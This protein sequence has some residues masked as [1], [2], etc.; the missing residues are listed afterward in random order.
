LGVVFHILPKMPKFLEVPFLLSLGVFLSKRSI[1]PLS[2]DSGDFIV[3]LDLLGQPKEFLDFRIQFF[4]QGI[5]EKMAAQGHKANAFEGGT[6]FLD[7]FFLS[8]WVPGDK[9]PQIYAWNR[10]HRPRI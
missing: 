1:A 8:G 6:D 10:T 7:K 3:I 5:G 9:V 2:P 4:H